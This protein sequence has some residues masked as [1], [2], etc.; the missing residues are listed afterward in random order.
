MFDILSKFA[1]I[2][3][4]FSVRMFNICNSLKYDLALNWVG[5]HVIIFKRRSE[6]HMQKESNLNFAH[7]FSAQLFSNTLTTPFV[8]QEN[9]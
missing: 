1:I 3:N 2:C 9:K 5:I 6:F 8:T 7:T 4:P